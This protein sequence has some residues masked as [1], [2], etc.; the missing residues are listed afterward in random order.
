MAGFN[1]CRCYRGNFGPRAMTPAR[2]LRDSTGLKSA[3]RR[4]LWRRSG[5]HEPIERCRLGVGKRKPELGATPQHVGGSSGEF[6]R[7]QIAH[8][9]FRQCCA[10]SRAEIGG[11]TRTRKNA[12][13]AVAIGGGKPA[14][15]RRFKEWIVPREFLC[16]GVRIAGYASGQS[17]ACCPASAMH[18]K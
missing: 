6:L 5:G 10:E 16:E 11:R 17:R 13:R 2:D 9:G 12:L 15:M 18:A 3:M 14:R 1:G 7:H 4:G 8:L